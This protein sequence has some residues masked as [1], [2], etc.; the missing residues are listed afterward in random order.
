MYLGFDQNKQEQFCGFGNYSL[1]YELVHHVYTCFNIS[2]SARCIRKT[3]FF[4]KPGQMCSCVVFNCFCPFPL[5]RK[6]SMENVT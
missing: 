3:N 4:F 2:K 6:F 5:C 1:R